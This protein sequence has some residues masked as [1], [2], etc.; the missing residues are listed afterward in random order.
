MRRGC[1]FIKHTTPAPRG[2]DNNA[3]E[4]RVP[5]RAE[6]V[7]T[8]RLVVAHLA[9]RMSMPPS[10]VQDLQ[11]AISEAC[12]NVVRH[13]YPEEISEEA[14]LLVRCSTD[15]EKIIAE[16]IDRG[17]GFD[18]RVGRGDPRQR[19]RFRPHPDPPSDG[20]GPVQQFA[21]LRHDHPHGE[22]VR[23]WLMVDGQWL[24]GSS[25]P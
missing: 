15:G 21:G 25:L 19:G 13:A 17:C 23:K 6:Y 12:A 10:A 18:G 1:S 11:V 9:E 7:A 16:V 3:I 24:M 5:S 8:I 4:V 20:S 22:I 2:A 14:E